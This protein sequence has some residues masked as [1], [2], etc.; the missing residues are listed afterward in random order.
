MPTQRVSGSSSKAGIEGFP[1]GLL[2]SP[3]RL[4]EN[5]AAGRHVREAAAHGDLPGGG[6]CERPDAAPGAVP[7]LLLLRPAGGRVPH[8]PGQPPAPGAWATLTPESPAERHPA[9]QP[10]RARD[11]ALHRA[12]GH[13]PR[14]PRLLPAEGGCSPP[15]TAGKLST[16]ASPAALLSSPTLAHYSPLLVTPSL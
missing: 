14:Q 12:A 15:L 8:T 2:L 4:R 7:G 6:V 10:H 16:F 1:Q 9:E 11:A 5:H 13:P 3:H